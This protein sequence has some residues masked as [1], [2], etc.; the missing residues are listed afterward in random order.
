[1]N[2]FFH[3]VGIVQFF[4]VT[5]PRI[6]CI[7][8]RGFRALRGQFCGGLAYWRGGVFAGGVNQKRVSLRYA[9]KYA[10]KHGLGFREAAALLRLVVGLPAKA[11]SGGALRGAGETGFEQVEQSGH[12][13]VPPMCQL[14]VDASNTGQLV[15]SI[16]PRAGD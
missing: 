7:T 8:G 11:K 3:R 6:I 1:M 4:C 14:I 9:Y 12:G 10:C 15:L 16:N 5:A 13:A 2:K